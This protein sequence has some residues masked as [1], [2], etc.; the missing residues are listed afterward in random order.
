M[1]GASVLV[2]D[3]SA[4]SR[5]ALVATFAGDPRFRVVGEAA[6]GREAVELAE[7]LRPDLVTMDLQ[8]P[9][10][11]G[12]EAIEEIMAR[13]P[14][15][16]LVVTGL[17]SWRGLDPSFEALR[18]GALELVQ[19]PSFSGTSEQEQLRERA[20]LLSTVPVL[21]HV[22]AARRRRQAARDPVRPEGAEAQIVGLGASTGGPGVVKELIDAL[23]PD[24]PVPIV[25]VQHLADVYANGFVEWLGRGSRV[26]VREAVP[27]S[28]LEPGVAVVAARGPHVRVT[29]RGAIEADAGPPRNG[30]CP[31][32][33]VTFDSIASAYGP[34][35]VGVLLTGMGRDGAQ[36]LLR[37]REAGGVTLAQDEATSA[38]FGMPKAA[39]ELGAATV[40]VSRH[41]LA[42]ALL[43]L[44]ERHRSAG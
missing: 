32:I 40:T 5:R 31:S 34:G 15:R 1:T 18:R 23:P 20:F 36:G 11:D 29:A 16:I 25:L 44:V 38:V 21:P 17:P 8:M 3:D 33:D 35:A 22:D 12:L 39:L 10:M 4:L 42:T 7:R 19:K 24:F 9:V 2:A 30:H 6:T 43:R 37:I 13:A 28:R 26:R 41:E 27:G 14:T